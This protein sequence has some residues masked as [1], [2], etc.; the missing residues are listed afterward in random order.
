VK[1]ERKREGERRERESCAESL[2]E[3]GAT[4][5]ISKGLTFNRTL[6]YLNPNF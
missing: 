6:K 4:I 3:A 5:S 2:P 1:R